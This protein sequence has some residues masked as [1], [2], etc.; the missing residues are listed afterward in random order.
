[1]LFSCLTRLLFTRVFVDQ[2]VVDC[3]TQCRVALEQCPQ[4]RVAVSCASPAS[5]QLFCR[6]VIRLIV[7][8]CGHDPHLSVPSAIFESLRSIEDRE[9]RAVMQRNVVLCGGLAALPGTLD[10]VRDAL[11]RYIRPIALRCISDGLATWRGG[12]V[13]AA[14]PSFATL[15]LTRAAYEEMGPGVV[16][17]RFA[18]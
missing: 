1:M 13:V 14:R 4:V 7:R 15:C 8:Q 12:S 3:V 17:L 6:D 11:G 10:A 9:M 5:S 2:I 16:S 18:M